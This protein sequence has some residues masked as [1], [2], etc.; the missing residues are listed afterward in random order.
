MTISVRFIGFRP[1]N[2]DASWI[3]VPNIVYTVYC[4]DSPMEL[5][6]ED[7]WHAA[8]IC[9][10]ADM[11]WGLCCFRLGIIDK[12]AEAFHPGW[13]SSSTVIPRRVAEAAGDRGVVIS[14]F[15]F[16]L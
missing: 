16:N 3:S 1:H 9:I 11:L 14:V 7:W 8:I 15:N 6:V 2:A 13:S 4:P 12:G 10:Y 5:G